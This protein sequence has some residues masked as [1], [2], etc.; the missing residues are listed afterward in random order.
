MTRYLLDTNII[1]DLVRNPGGLATKH[2]QRAGDENVCTSIIVAAELRYGCAKKGSAKLLERV[3]EVL[4]A[5]PVLALEGPA[6][7][8]YGS[9]RATLEREGRT[10]GHNGLLIAAHASSLGTTLVTANVGEFSR[11]PDLTIE[12]WIE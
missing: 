2:L 4:S 9:I 11:I 7:I 10:V 12:N 6:D 3:E 8:V 1:S 5:I